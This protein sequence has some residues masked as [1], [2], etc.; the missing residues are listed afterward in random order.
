MKKLI[1]ITVTASVYD[2]E[3]RATLYAAAATSAAMRAVTALVEPQGP[4][5]FFVAGGSKVEVKTREELWAAESPRVRE[6][7]ERAFADW[8]AESEVE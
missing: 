4:E 5:R 3:D 6:L 7:F 8:S 2:D 1:T